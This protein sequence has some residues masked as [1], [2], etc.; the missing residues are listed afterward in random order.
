MARVVQQQRHDVEGAA[1]AGAI[2]A[3]STNFK[4]L[5]PHD[6]GRGQSGNSEKE[7]FYQQFQG[8]DLR[9]S[10]GQYLRVSVKK[11]GLTYSTALHI[12]KVRLPSARPSNLSRKPLQT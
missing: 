12:R 7:T 1:S 9:K 5:M 2:P 4:E 3:A 6:M 10:C 11:V 8:P